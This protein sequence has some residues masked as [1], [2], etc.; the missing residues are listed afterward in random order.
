MYQAESEVQ[1][2]QARISSWLIQWPVAPA[3][4]QI[5]LV[6]PEIAHHQAHIAAPTT[7]T[8]SQ[9]TKCRQSLAIRPLACRRGNIHAALTQVA[10]CNVALISGRKR[11]KIEGHP[12]RGHFAIVSFGLLRGSIT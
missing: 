11:G 12:R 6:N 1:E 7:P 4:G 5:G 10:S 2:V 3:S 8:P 9:K